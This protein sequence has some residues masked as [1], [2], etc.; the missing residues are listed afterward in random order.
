MARVFAV[1]NALFRAEWRGQKSF[2]SVIGNNFFIVSA[3]LLQKA[4]GFIYLIVGLVMLFPLSTDPLRKIPASRLEL[5]PLEARDRRLLRLLSPWVNPMTW[6]IAALALW[7]ARGRVTLGLWGLAA[8]LVFAGFLLSDL[9]FAPVYGMWRR[10]PQ[11]PGPLNQLIRKNV[12]ELFSTLDFYCALLLSAAT[13]A[14]RLLGAPLPAEAFLAV[15]ILVVLALSSYAQCLF[16]LDGAGGLSRYRL[17]PLRGWQILAAKDAA[18]LAVLVP[19]LL[20]L[21]PWAGLGAGFVALA[22]GQEPSVRRIR[23][24]TR[25]RFSSGSSLVLGLVQAGIMAAAAAGIQFTSTLLLAPC[26]A[27]WAISLWGCGRIL[28]GEMEMSAQS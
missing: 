21:A 5:W 16:G 25:W 7:A 17:L 1:L 14:Y 11:F 15:T 27:A 8:G 18:F 22:V 2:Q 20:P 6:A 3:V 10:I 28:E 12:R 24:Q 23:P 26:L 4:G 19:L 13:L 9:P